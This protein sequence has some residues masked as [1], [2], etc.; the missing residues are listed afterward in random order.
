MSHSL[1]DIPSHFLSPQNQTLDSSWGSF[2]NIRLLVRGHFLC[3]ILFAGHSLAG[4]LP[5][6]SHGNFLG[7]S[8]SSGLDP[9]L[10]LWHL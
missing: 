7:A 10:L 4:T 6:P 8:V 1:S 3:S 5:D 9:S 2:L